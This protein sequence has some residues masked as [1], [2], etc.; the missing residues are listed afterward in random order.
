MV[1][2]TVT[3]VDTNNYNKSYFWWSIYSM[4]TLNQYSTVYDYSQYYPAGAQYDATTGQYYDPQTGQ[5]YD[6]SQYY[7]Q[8]QTDKNTQSKY[9][10]K[11]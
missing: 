7:Q 6:Y 9:H 1:Q 11:Y 10:E 3:R 4:A 5:Y 8:Y 2:Q